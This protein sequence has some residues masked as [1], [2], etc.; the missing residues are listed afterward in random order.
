VDEQDD[1]EVLDVEIAPT[2]APEAAN[3][4][5]PP[6]SEPEKEMLAAS[7][8]D[9]AERVEPEDVTPPLPDDPGVPDDEAAKP[10]KRFSL[11]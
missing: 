4:R 3:D 8:A 2:V 9:V 10:R 6:V 7:T 11:F 5:T 1:A